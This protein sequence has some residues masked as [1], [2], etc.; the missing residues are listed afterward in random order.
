MSKFVKAVQ[1]LSHSVIYITDDGKYI[2]YL[3]GTW[4]WRT[5]NPGDIHAGKVSKEYNQ[6]GV[7]NNKL[8]VFPDYETGQ[9]ALI[10]LLKTPLYA[11]RSI[12]QLVEKYA[13]PKDSNKH[14]A[15]YKEA[16]HQQT[17]VMDDT[18]IKY[19]TPEQFEAL[20]KTIIQMEGYDNT[21]TKIPRQIIE[22]YKISCTQS[23]K[24]GAISSYCISDTAWITKEECEKLIKQSEIEAE[25]CHP[26]NGTTYL[27]TSGHSSFQED[28]DDIVEK[29]HEK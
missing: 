3:G 25:I 22:V 27:R 24:K 23:N 9:A 20:W 12:D 16:L 15:E 8:A 7:T 28:F 21:E 19:F 2:R 14:N 18:K 26:K 6:I 17:G 29:P 13:P 11:N 4:P 10:A 5:N 1:G